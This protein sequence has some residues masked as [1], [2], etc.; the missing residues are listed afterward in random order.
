MNTAVAIPVAITA[1]GT[2]AVSAVLQQRSARLAPA[3]ESLSWRLLI[4]LLREPSWLAGMF[5]ALAG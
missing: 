2:F 1:A 4:D 3:D 5:C